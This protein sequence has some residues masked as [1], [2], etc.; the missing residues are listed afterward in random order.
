MELGQRVALMPRRVP[1]GVARPANRVI[2]TFRGHWLVAVL[3]VI[4]AACAAVHRLAEIPVQR[5]AGH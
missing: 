4:G 5:V 2:A 3:L 1:K